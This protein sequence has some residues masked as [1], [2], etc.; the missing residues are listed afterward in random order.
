[1]RFQGKGK[2]KQ[3]MRRNRII[4]VIVLLSLSGCTD[5]ARMESGNGEAKSGKEAQEEADPVIE[6]GYALF[7]EASEAGRM[8]DLE[9]CR[10]IVNR[11]G[12]HGYAAVDGRN[13]IDMAESEQVIRFCGKAD[14]K[15]E[16]KLTLIKINDLE[17]ILD[18][19]VKYDLETED[20]EMEVTTS[21]YKY[22]DQDMEKVFTSSFH[23]ERWE[24]TQ[25]G[26]LMFSGSY[27]RRQLSQRGRAAFL[28]RKKRSRFRRWF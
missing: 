4:L 23:A 22:G 10:S 26:Y 7:R 15:E 17:G 11:F 13:Q 28:Q 25:D 19:I 27:S 1:M 21:Y 14:A 9:M 12:D 6:M 2:Y 20:G 8:D 16:G 18:G 24:Y 5:T 3:K